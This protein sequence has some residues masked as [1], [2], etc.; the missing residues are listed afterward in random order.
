M[1]RRRGRT[2]FQRSPV[3]ILL[4]VLTLAAPVA[5]ATPGYPPSRVENVHDSIH[6]V[7]VADPYRWLEDAKSPEVQRWMEAQDTLARA[8]LRALPHRAEFAARL[9]ELSYIDAIDAPLKRGKRYFYKRRNAKQEKAILYCREGKNGPERALLDPN[10]WSAEGNWSLNRWVPSWDGEKVAYTVSRNFADEATLYVLDV[11]TGKRSQIDVIEGA[12]Y[13]YA[14]WTPK[15]DAFYYTWIPTDST[16]PAA[17]VPGYQEVRFHR[18][19]EDPKQDERIRERTGD[20]G[21][22][23]GVALSKDGHW[24][25]WVRSHGW[26]SSDVYFKD[27]RGGGGKGDF[28][29]LTV[30]SD[31]LYYVRAFRDRFYVHTNEGASRWCVYRVDPARPARE[32]WVKV[33]PERNDATLDEFTIAGSRLVLTYIVDASTLLEIRDLDGRKPREVALPTIGTVKNIT[34][35]DVDDEAFFEF[36]SFTTP[37]EIYE[38]AVSAGKMRLW[39]R[40][41]VPID[42]APYTVDRIFV[43]S[44][45]GARVP[46]FI[47]H[48]KDLARDG[49]TP[50]LLTGYGGF[51]QGQS[52]YFSARSYL[53]LERGGAYALACLRGGNEY[54]EEWHRAGMLTKKQT[55]FDDF[56]AV[57]E[58]LIRERYTS[59]DRLVISGGSNA[60]LLVGAAMT[61]RPDLYRGVVCGAPLL[62]MVRYHRFGAGSTWVGEYGSADDSAQFRAL[63]AYSPYHQVKPDVKYPPTLMMSAD[64]DDRVDPMHARKFTA[65]L[66]AAGGGP[67]YLRIEREAGHR[68]AD[69]V[70]SSVESGADLY[71]FL[72]SLVAARAETAK[73]A[74]P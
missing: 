14:S 70:R 72:L 33:V 50:L 52:P 13:G 3:S 44:K 21:V 23:Q 65:A 7:D 55:V 36:E 9:R 5:V 56:I 11:T 32:N 67:V 22:F 73:T 48:R 2:G 41:K 35:D 18:L 61:Q 19:G 39:D 40:V 10:V 60:G 1:V 58:H 62:D 6:G 53:W 74:A 47:V 24:L 16:I 31:A 59:A 27:M 66:Q 51:Q 57:S 30:G 17:A 71:A 68:G 20:S 54:G 64:S 49:S 45:D 8:T 25:L 37:K 4:A 63:L 42:A 34:G 12:R 15:N 46:V 26:N 69:R 28:V 43:T 29:P 38:L